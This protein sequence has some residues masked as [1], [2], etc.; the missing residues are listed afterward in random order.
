MLPSFSA[1][2]ILPYVGYGDGSSF[3]AMFVKQT[4]L[5]IPFPYG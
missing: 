1:M 5:I 2:V 3:G 4:T